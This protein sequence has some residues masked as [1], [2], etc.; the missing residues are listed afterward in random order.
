MVGQED[1]G[2]M[3]ARQESWWESVI[4]H[5]TRIKREIKYSIS[6]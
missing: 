4:G 1:R 6:S 5:P 3:P 2:G